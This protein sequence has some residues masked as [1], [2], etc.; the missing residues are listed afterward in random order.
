MKKSSLEAFAEAVLFEKEGRDYFLSSI[1]KV[2]NQSTRDLFEHMAKEEVKHIKV[3]NDLF[4]RIE[5][6]GAW[7]EKKEDYSGLKGK[8]NKFLEIAKT[9]SAKVDSSSDDV[10]ALEHAMEI[11]KKGKIYY[12]KK[13]AETDIEF[14]KKFFSLL[15]LEEEGHYLAFY[16][17]REY[18]L[19]PEGWFALKER[20]GF[21]GA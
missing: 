1:K 18:L 20:S 14:E 8:E 6:T 4:Q 17:A 16:D 3:I 10:L 21:D 15:A 5:E 13:A 7:E 12:E 11:E 19:D 9:V 2:K